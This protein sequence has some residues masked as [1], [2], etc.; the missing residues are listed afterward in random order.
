M[1]QTSVTKNSSALVEFTSIASHRPGSHLA[2]VVQPV[3]SR[4]VEAGDRTIEGI[5]SSAGLVR[6]HRFTVDS[7]A[8]LAAKLDAVHADD[9]DVVLALPARAAVVLGEPEELVNTARLL[10]GIGVAASAVPLA[11][12]ALADQLQRAVADAVGSPVVRCQ[13]FPHALVGPAGQLRALL[14]DLPE[15]DSDADRLTAAVLANRHRLVLDAVSLLFHILDGT[16]ADVTIVAGRA[17][18]GGRE[19]LVLIDPA[20]R[21]Q[22]L[23]S[24]DTEVADRRRVAQERRQ[25]VQHNVLATGSTLIA[26]VLGFALQAITSHALHPGQYGKAFAVLSFYALLT[27]PAAAFG[28]LVAWQTS[29]EL[30]TPGGVGEKSGALL[31]QLTVRLM[32]GGGLIGAVFIVGGS[33]LGTY[34][35][36]PI[37]YIAIGAVS[38]PFTLATQPLLGSLQGEQRFVPWSVLS[39]FVSLSRLI[40]VVAFIFAYGA[41][42]V[43]F[44]TTVASAVTF[45]VCLVAVWPR[46]A[47]FKGGFD[48]APAVPFIV[49]AFAST[50]AVGVFLGADVIVVEHF[51]N[52]VMGGQYAVVAVVGNSVFF[53]TGGVASVIF[54]MVAARH[55]RDRST[56]GV[57]GASLA[58]C[59]VAGLVGTLGLELFGHF[60]LLNFAGK[61]YVAGARYLGWYALGMGIMGCVVVLVNTQQS[62]N[63]LSLLWVL[64]PA[65]VLRPALLVLFHRT[66]MTVV[67]VSDL[68]VAAFTLVMAA[69]YIITERAR[70]RSGDGIGVSQPDQSASRARVAIPMT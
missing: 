62:L 7:L 21:G 43:L 63:R 50:L 6:L 58:L 36:V 26:G 39:V 23:A 47:S 24:A 45:T 69:M 33:L 46:I 17:H 38:T 54:P 11:S 22:A 19:P 32:V 34:L 42:G 16:G 29:R 8:Q 55:A 37:S 68:S 51:F 59:A 44:G 49:T 27:R 12:P 9:T 4:A 14:A 35:H 48:W 25:F 52:K 53:A 70:Q 30:A 5:P 60:I 41:F 13:C 20:P 40:F 18:A 65:T 61:T 3:G 10:G 28:R 67:V 57:M 1:A 2:S 15:G 66:L 31:R 64:I 56:F